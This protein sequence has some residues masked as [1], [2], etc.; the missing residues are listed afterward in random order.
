VPDLFG[1]V[2]SARV[3]GMLAAHPSP[4]WSAFECTERTKACSSTP[5]MFP[6]H[7][8]GLLFLS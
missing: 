1:A 6:A 4:A 3:P 8:G 7:E 2:H 5:V